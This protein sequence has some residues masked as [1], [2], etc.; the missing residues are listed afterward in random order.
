MSASI[1]P[2]RTLLVDD[3][4]LANR[5]LAELL[6]VHPGLEVVAQAGNLEEAAARAAE[7]APE[8]VFLDIQIRRQNGF[9]LLPILA[10]MEHPPVIVFVT[11][12]EEHAVKAFESAALDYL[13]KPVHPARLAITVSRIL[14]ATK[15]QP[16]NAAVPPAQE[17]P[18]A[19][20]SAKA[21]R[22]EMDDLEVLR[23]GKRIRIIK[24]VQIRAIQSE[25]S[26][27]RLLLEEAGACMVKQPLAHWENRLPAGLLFKVSR[28]LLV[29]LRWITRLEV[30]NRNRT[31]VYLDGLSTPLILSR[32]ESIR[33]RRQL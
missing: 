5:L 13:L 3:E 1:L 8:V 16:A 10:Q 28:S 24:P 20:H 2:L 23:D 21:H 25:G 11:A 29:N 15:N 14:N 26:Y 18:A 4:R 7:Y 12:Y 22:L 19:E 30:H 33:L 32:L 27:T 31:H 17:P 6:L 9:D